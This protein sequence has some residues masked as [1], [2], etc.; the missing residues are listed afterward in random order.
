VEV[1]MWWKE[2]GPFALALLASVAAA[3]SAVTPTATAVDRRDDVAALRQFLGHDRSYS[4]DARATAKAE[5]DRLG[6][7]GESLSAAAFQLAVA[8]VA[9]LA[10]NGH[11]LLIPAF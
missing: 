9:A 6:R 7:S 5:I 8:R 1:S 10:G 3:A 2:P 11:T 4:P